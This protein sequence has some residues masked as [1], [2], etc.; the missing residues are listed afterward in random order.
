MDRTSCDNARL[1]FTIAFMSKNVL[2][3]FNIIFFVF[4]LDLLTAL[5]CPAFSMWR[6]TCLTCREREREREKEKTKKEKERE[7]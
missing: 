4:V 1:L 3:F 7:A 2:Q 5:P 6:A